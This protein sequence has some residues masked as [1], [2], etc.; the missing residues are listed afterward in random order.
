[1]VSS[2]VGPVGVE[3]GRVDASGVV[4]ALSGWTGVEVGVAEGR[5]P[6]VDAGVGSAGG[7]VGR[8]GGVVAQAPRP[9]RSS[10]GVELRPRRVDAGSVVGA[11]A[12]A[13]AGAGVGFQTDAGA[14]AEAEGVDAGVE[15][16]V[17]QPRELA[18][19]DVVRRGALSG[20]AY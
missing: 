11:G 6:T 18:S 1:M 15:D 13:G 2:G 9:A 17:T 14:A 20:R 4:A 8:S 3:V 12:G 7:V 19:V 5:Q 16:W 10:A